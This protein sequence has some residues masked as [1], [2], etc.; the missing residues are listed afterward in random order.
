MG[1]TSADPA[2]R[3]TSGRVAMTVLSKL[4]TILKT[5]LS[6]SLEDCNT[7]VNHPARPF[8][9]PERHAQAYSGCQRQFFPLGALQLSSRERGVLA[10]SRNVSETVLKRC[11]HAAQTRRGNVTEMSAKVASTP[12]VHGF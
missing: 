4:H 10:T 2:P 12:L 3:S 8:L 9:Y 6:E 5:A 1:L 7:P 11:R